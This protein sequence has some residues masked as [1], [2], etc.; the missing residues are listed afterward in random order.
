[1]SQVLVVVD[2]LTLVALVVVNIGLLGSHRW[3]VNQ[4][5][6][7]VAE[8]EECLKPAP[9][10]V[11]RT[12]TPPGPSPAEVDREIRQARERYRS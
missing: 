12:R 11:H 6:A 4:L 10:T 3:D 8:L 2:V 5:R 7:Q 9:A 1:V